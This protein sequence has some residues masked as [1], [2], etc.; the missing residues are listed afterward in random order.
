MAGDVFLKTDGPVV[1]G[2]FAGN[3]PLSMKMGD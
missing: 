3:S 1:A 2:L